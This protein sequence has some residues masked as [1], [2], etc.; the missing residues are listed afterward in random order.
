MDTVNI[1][2]VAKKDHAGIKRVANVPCVIAKMADGY[3]FGIG[4]KVAVESGNQA[5]PMSTRSKCHGLIDP[6]LTAKQIDYI[7]R[8]SGSFCVILYPEHYETFG[9]SPEFQTPETPKEKPAAKPM[10]TKSAV[11]TD[12]VLDVSSSEDPFNGDDVI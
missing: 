4:L 3:D 11:V 1:G 7:R 6:T 12:I 2:Y 5:V 9:F 8:E 10:P